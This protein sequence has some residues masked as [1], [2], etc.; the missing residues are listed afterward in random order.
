MTNAAEKQEPSSSELAKPSYSL[1]QLTLYFLKLGSLGFGGPIA[2]VGYMHRDL[3]EDRRWI[4]EASYQEGLTLA[5]V[6]PGPLAA[7]L[8]FYMGYVHYGIIRFYP[9]WYC[10]CLALLFY[11]CGIGL[12]LHQ[13]WGAQLDAGS[14]LRGWSLRHW[15]HCSKRLQIDEEDHWQR[16]VTLGNLSGQ[17]CLDH[18]HAIG[19]NRTHPGRR[20]SHTIFLKR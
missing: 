11:G 7:Q 13:L 15:H 6:A 4:S 9:R 18:H 12:G 17:C 20:N 5:Q 3:A 19:T 16:L 10:L 1:W 14:I 8:G 2:L